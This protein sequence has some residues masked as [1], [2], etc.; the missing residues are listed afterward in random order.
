MKYTTTPLSQAQAMQ[1]RF[2]RR[3][4]DRLDAAPAELPHDISERLRAARVQALAR[5]KVVRVQAR[6]AQAVGVHAD[7][8]AS[9]SFP[10]TELGW[11]GR[12]ASALPLLALLAGLIALNTVIDDDRAREVADV[13]SALLTD[14][15]P[16]AAYADPGFVE[17]LRAGMDSGRNTL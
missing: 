11:W 1:D 7:G 2:A 12:L 16:P 14:D 17:Y 5:R 13:D 4:A 15:L 9:L 6:A 8:T 3:L 10:R